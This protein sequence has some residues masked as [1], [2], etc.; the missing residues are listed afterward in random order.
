MI[1]FGED[2][3]NYDSKFKLFMFTK[4]ANPNFLP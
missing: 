1:K 3:I 4:V 2:T